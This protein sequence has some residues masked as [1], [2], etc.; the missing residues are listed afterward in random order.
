MTVELVGEGVSETEKK[1]RQGASSGG[2]EINWAAILLTMAQKEHRGT[3]LTHHS[4]Q[5]E[6]ALDHTGLQCRR[7]LRPGS[8]HLLLHSANTEKVTA[9]EELLFPVPPAPLGCLLEG[10][11][12]PKL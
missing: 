3:V 5:P 7:V 2:R 8:W 1:L 6:Q 9:N 4:S 10:P 11:S 12:Q